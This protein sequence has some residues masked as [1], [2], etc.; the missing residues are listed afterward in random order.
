MKALW[1]TGLLLLFSSGA[2]ATAD[3]TRAAAS[4][5]SGVFEPPRMAPEFSLP[6][7]Q[8]GEFTL[9]EHR[10]QPLVL[11]FGFSSCPQICPMTLANLVKVKRQLGAL[12]DQVQVVFM[13]VDP[14]RDSIDQLRAYLANF[15]PDFIGLT[16][17]PEQ[18]AAVR[19]AYGITTQREDY[20]QGRYDVHHSSFVFLVDRQGLLRALVPFGTGPDDIAHDLRVLLQEDVSAL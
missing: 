13:T 11:S 16:G 19:E 1:F 15:H 12:A 8:G 14:E 17:A 4:L 9:S 2:L 10:G 3:R 20:G 5:K 6:S 18:L 7:S